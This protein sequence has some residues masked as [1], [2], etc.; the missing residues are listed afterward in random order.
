MEKKDNNIKLAQAEVSFWWHRF[1]VREK[2]FYGEWY[3]NGKYVHFCT[4]GH[5][6]KGKLL[7]Y[8]QNGDNWSPK[9]VTVGSSTAP[10]GY[11]GMAFWAKKKA[12]CA[13]QKIEEELPFYVVKTDCGNLFYDTKEEAKGIF[14]AEIASGVNN[15]VELY[16]SR[17]DNKYD[18]EIISRWEN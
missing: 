4:N 7:V 11:L 6:N 14:E 15:R 18:P 1:F 17:P 16:E 3:R 9:W 5:T 8:F 2:Y 10:V 12:L 13:V